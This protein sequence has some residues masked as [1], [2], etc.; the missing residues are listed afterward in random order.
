MAEERAAYLRASLAPSA[1]PAYGCAVAYRPTAPIDPT[2]LLAEVRSVYEDLSNRPVERTC[3]RLT[4][5]CQFNLTG[6]MPLLTRGEALYAA[7]ALRASG[8]T[9][10]PERPDGACPLLKPDGKC[11]IYEARPFGCRTH[12]CAAAGGP[13]ARR[14]VLDLIRRLEV[15]DSK[16]GGSGSRP[17]PVAMKQVLSEEVPKRGVK[18]GV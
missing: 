17:L 5:C 3:T 9:K 2:A 15:V 8:R 11:M 13:Y 16:L 18:R 7:Q 12:F 4:E 14:D 1:S 6:A 10:L